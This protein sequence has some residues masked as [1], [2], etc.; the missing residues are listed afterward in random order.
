MKPAWHEVVASLETS[1]ARGSNGSN[2]LARANGLASAIVP[3]TDR[4]LPP[5]AWHEPPL[6][7]IEV[8]LAPPP[9]TT[10]GELL[11]RLERRMIVDDDGIAVA[12]L[13]LDGFKALNQEHG[14]AVGD[15]VLEATLER[16]EAA[17]GRS[18]TVARF[19]SDEFGV[20]LAGVDSA[21]ALAVA[22]RA[23]AAVA[24]PMTV[25]GV[26][27]R[28][29]AS[30]GVAC[31]VAAQARPED[32]V[33]DADR[34]LSRARTLGGGRAIVHDPTAAGRPLALA[35]LEIALRRTLDTDEFR[36]HYQ[37][38][39]SVKGGQVAGFEVHLWRRSGANGKRR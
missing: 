29:T 27:L 16:L 10:R 6:A 32:L 26:T 11:G 39:V 38:I 35:E 9:G 18:A 36:E 3:R 23:V 12:L 31:R 33:R 25:E 34:A 21:S 37:P 8:P 19:G 13:D 7:R 28:V 2:G 24:E 4:P 20:L 22:E 15:R 30:A 1:L 17:A 5:V 14:Y